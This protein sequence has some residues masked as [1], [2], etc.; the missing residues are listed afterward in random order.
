MS[1]LVFKT[2]LEAKLA[3]DK[4]VNNIR[5]FLISIES[6]ALSDDGLLKGRRQ[7]TLEVCEEGLTTKWSIVYPCSKGWAILLINKE[8]VQPIPYEIILEGVGGLLEEN[9]TL[10]FPEN[11]IL[12]IT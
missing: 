11:K 12:P 8:L 7:N 2:E 6:K 3:Q 4:I 5:D 10:A 9:I 1:Y